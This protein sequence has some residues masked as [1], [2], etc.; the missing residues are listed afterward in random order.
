MIDIHCHILPQMDDG[1]SS[2]EEALALARFCVEDGITHII[3]TPHCHKYIH[4]LRETILPKV[5]EFNRQLQEASIALMVLPGSEIQVVNTVEYQREYEAGLLCHLCDDPAFTLVEFNW[6]YELFPPNTVELLRWL[7]K[8]GT[9]PILAHPER[10]PY[11]VNNK[12]LLDSLVDTGAWVQ[13]TVDSI[14][15]NHGPDPRHAAKLLLGRYHDCVLATD[16]HNTKRC[17]GLSKGYDWVR[18]ELGDDA[19]DSMLKRTEQIL[20]TMQLHGKV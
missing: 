14:L 8:K 2:L 4:H 5:E 7:V 1:P 15:G 12:E 10:H 20:L 3:A 19:C 16:A 9:Q 6:A 17:S 18:A 11:F 13:I